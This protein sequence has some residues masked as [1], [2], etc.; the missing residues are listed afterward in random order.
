MTLI[1]ARL[2]GGGDYFRLRAAQLARVIMN[3]IV[4]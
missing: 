1:R 2:A 3:L 4:M